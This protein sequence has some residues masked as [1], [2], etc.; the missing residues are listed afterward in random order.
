MLAQRRLLFLLPFA[1]SLDPTHGGSQVMARM[2]T[3]L[4][5]RHQVAV[6]Y[7]RAPH[8]ALLDDTLSGQCA[9]VE[10]ITR[11]CLGDSFIQRWTSRLRLVT[12]L[13]QG[14]TIALHR[15][16]AAARAPPA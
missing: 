1:P 5:T 14:R 3:Q 9:L 11:P 13:S 2:L 7:L 8:E 6:L 12:G 15:A 4:A 16:I 10:E